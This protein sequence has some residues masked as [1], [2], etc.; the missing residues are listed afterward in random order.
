MKEKKQLNIEIGAHIQAAREAAGLT[1]ERFAELLPMA[2][3][4][5]SAVERGAVGIS[6]KTLVRICE[7]LSVSGDTLLF[8]RT[9]ENDADWIAARLKR[10]PPLKFKI[11][12]DMINTMFEALASTAEDLER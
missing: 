1:Q 3:Q 6:L 7:V 2:P 5:V 9:E 12:C 8:G 10:L 11:A 4:N